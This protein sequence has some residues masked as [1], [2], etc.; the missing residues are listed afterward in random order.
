[1]VHR[2]RASLPDRRERARAGASAH[3]RALPRGHPPAPADHGADAGF[4]RAQG[5]RRL[6]VRDH[7]RRADQGGRAARQVARP[8]GGRERRVE[9]PHPPATAVQ[10]RIEDQGEVHADLLAAVRSKT[11]VRVSLGGRGPGCPAVARGSQAEREDK[12]DLHEICAHA[13]REDLRFGRTVQQ[14][15]AQRQATAHHRRGAGD[16]PRETADDVYVQPHVLRVRRQLAY[17][18]QRHTPL[19][20]Q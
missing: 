2:P 13:R 5:R 17:D 10:S 1:M 12:P 18:I 6:P 9:R 20:H 7:P 19:R 4:R 15:R 8:L 16:R 3:G 11:R 14:P